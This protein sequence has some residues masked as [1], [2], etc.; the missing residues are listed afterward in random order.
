MNVHSG[1]VGESSEEDVSERESTHRELWNAAIS[2]PRDHENSL[3][4]RSGRWVVSAMECL[5]CVEFP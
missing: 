5:H 1:E 3:E 2:T 4:H